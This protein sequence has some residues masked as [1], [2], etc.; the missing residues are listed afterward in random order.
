VQKLEESQARLVG[1]ITRAKD[2]LK[3]VGI[4][5]ELTDRRVAKLQET[6]AARSTELELKVERTSFE[7]R[8]EMMHPDAR[9]ALRIV[10][11]SDH[12]G[13]LLLARALHGSWPDRALRPRL[14]GGCGTAGSHRA[15]KLADVPTVASADRGT[16][17]ERRGAGRAGALRELVE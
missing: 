12:L 9:E 17:V 2:R 4:N 13:N 7:M 8:G 15:R 14:T 1:E 3:R 16:G 11:G 5:Q 10:L 6:T